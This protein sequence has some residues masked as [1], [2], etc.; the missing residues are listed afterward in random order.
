MTTEPAVEPTKPRR[1][2]GLLIALIA[3]GVLLVLLVVGYFVAEGAAR[4]YASE[5]IH[6]ELVTAF[7]LEAD[8][9][10][11][12]DLGGGS[13]LL[14]A[15]S[16][17]VDRVDVAIDDVPLGELTGDVTLAATGIPLDTEQPADTIAATATIDEAN[18]AKLR[19][20]LSGVELD[21]ITL[22]DGVIDVSTT[23][24]ALFLTVPVS[25]SIVPTAENGQ[26]V[27]TPQSVTVNG[28]V[29]PIDELSS[30][31]LAGVASKFLGAQSLCVAQYLPA[32]VTLDDVKVTSDELRLRFTGDNVALGGAG[33][34]TKGTC[35]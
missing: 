13:L 32:A 24:N 20:F 5:R 34:S 9:P 35:G 1:R 23:V 11:D 22:G 3:L 21:A 4:G 33:L 30:G 18:V 7:E 8:H 31:P 6:D 17:K 19:D 2:R 15:A 12:I 28:A 27:F 16:G 25:A 10:M 14:Q 29:V 26:L